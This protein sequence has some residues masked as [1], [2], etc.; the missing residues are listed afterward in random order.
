MTLQR[1]KQ[2]QENPDMS[3]NQEKLFQLMK[4]STEKELGFFPADRE[5]FAAFFAALKD[6]DLLDFV[7]EISKNDR[8]STI[9]VPLSLTEF[10]TDRMAKLQPEKVLI[11]EAEKHL[12][13]L[14]EM[15]QGLQAA[16]F[17]LTAQSKFMQ[18]LLQLA[19][20]EYKNVQIRLESIYTEC[21][22]AEK[23]DYIFTLPAFGQKAEESG[24]AFLTTDSE[25]I[26]LENMLAHLQVRGT[27]DIVVPAK[28]T[29][30]GSDYAKLRTYIAEKYQP[31]SIYL[32]PEGIFRPLTAVKTY[33]LSISTERKKNVDIGALILQRDS[34][35]IRGRKSV[36]VRELICRDNWPI[37]L[38]LSEDDANIRQFKN[39][40]LPKVRLKEVAEVF[41]GKSILKKD[42]SPGNIAVLNISDIENG[43]INYLN[44]DTIAEEERKVKRYELQSGDVLL[45]CRGTAI[46]AAVFTAQ[47]GITIASANLLVIRP[48]EKVLGEFIRIFLESPL[49]LAI[50]KSFQRGTNII[51]LNPADLMEMEMPLLALEK[52]DELIQ[53]YKSEAFLYRKIC[54][55]AEKRLADEKKKIHEQLMQQAGKDEQVIDINC[56]DIRYILKEN[57]EI[58]DES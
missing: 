18:I 34:L 51:N 39:S 47:A 21:L 57:P 48:K 45:S 41:R 20:A 2:L 46:K 25:G 36:A 6:I 4:K 12:A 35:M 3:L 22:Q 33:L 28:L 43:E 55:M 23:F 53:H 42:A 56:R 8:S 58:N 10:I 54:K 30:A 5:D 29:F 15:L 31:E 40:I 27:L 16:Q 7:L 38:L 44:M 19:F 26:A 13:G 52:Q 9:I 1:L 50:I 17:T 37:D 11:T 49:G 32:L 24:I 14:R